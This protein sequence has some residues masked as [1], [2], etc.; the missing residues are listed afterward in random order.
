[1]ATLADATLEQLRSVPLFTSASGDELQ[2]LASR[3]KRVTFSARQTILTEGEPGQGLYVLLDGSADVII[4]DAVHH[5]VSAGDIIGEISML[6]RG[7]ATATV[8]A[9]SE[10]AALL[11]THDD[12]AAAVEEHGSIALRVIRILVERMHGD[13]MRLAAYNRTLLD[14][15][16]QV[17]Q[18]TDAAAAVEASIYQPVMLD[19]A[20]RR[21][22]ELGQL[23]RVFRTMAA[24]VEAR[25]RRLRQEVQ[26]LRI[27]LDQR[28]ADEQV[29]AITDTDYFQ[30]LQRSADRLRSRSQGEG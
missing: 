14:Y 8:V 15:I 30:E 12:F 10:L 25:E 2:A 13:Q 29:A 3:A 18:I 6:G 24:E 9:R 16:D 21:E 28:R 17:K 27:T 22:D 26:R 19:E 5:Q 11:L 4:D 1:V 7:N 20:A 23:A